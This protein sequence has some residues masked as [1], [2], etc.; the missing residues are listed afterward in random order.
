MFEVQPNR[1]KH[2][3]RVF[4]SDKCNRLS[5]RKAIRPTKE[6]LAQLVWAVPVTQVALEF[7]V[8]GRAVKKWCAQL[9]LETPG[10]GYW[11]THAWNNK[12]HAV[13]ADV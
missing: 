11:S 4:C 10:R 3:L 9:G 1:L 2:G 12:V 13:L 5:R 8:S 7:G 6:Q